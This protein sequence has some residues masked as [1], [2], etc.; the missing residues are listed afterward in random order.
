MPSQPNKFSTRTATSS[1]A[2]YLTI[3]EPSL[4]LPLGRC[5]VRSTVATGDSRLH[6]TRDRLSRTT[7]LKF[8]AIDSFCSQFMLSIQIVL[9]RNLHDIG[10]NHDHPLARSSSST[11]TKPGCLSGY[12][13]ELR[14]RI[15]NAR[16]GF[17]AN[18]RTTTHFPRL[19][20]GQSDGVS[21]SKSLG[22]VRVPIPR[23]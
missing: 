18:W 2:F 13:V 20:F 21:R 9:L 3:D 19:K 12:G 6:C 22:L 10:Q 4:M 17:R 16:D 23:E 7:L 1:F 14:K 15:C 5:T 11:A 8:G